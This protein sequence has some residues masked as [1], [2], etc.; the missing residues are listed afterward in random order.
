M[1]LFV[2]CFFPLVIVGSLILVV[3][4]F[5][6]QTA[7]FIAS[8]VMAVITLAVYWFCEIEDEN[9]LWALIPAALTVLLYW[10]ST[11]IDISWSLLNLLS[12]L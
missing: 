7:V 4:A 3:L 11:K 6:F 5:P 8:V 2:L 12:E 1:E 9:R 10:L